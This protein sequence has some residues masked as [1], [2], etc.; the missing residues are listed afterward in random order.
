MLLVS[1]DDHLRLLVDNRRNYDRSLF[2][3]SPVFYIK[4]SVGAGS[5]HRLLRFTAGLEDFA[6]TNAHLP[7]TMISVNMRDSL[8]RTCLFCFANVN[9]YVEDIEWHSVFFFPCTVKPRE[10]FIQAC[11]RFYSIFFPASPP[12][13]SIVSKIFL[14]ARS[15]RY[16]TNELARSVAGI[17]ACRLQ[18]FAS[19]SKKGPLNPLRV[20]L[21]RV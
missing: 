21:E 7:G 9:V 16:L 14:E 6:R 4:P 11:P 2:L 12:E 5:F 13:R 19:W 3:I 20:A 17:H 8:K 18:A 15:N 10:L 1:C